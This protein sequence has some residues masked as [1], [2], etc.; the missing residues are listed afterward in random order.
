MVRLATFRGYGCFE[1]ACWLQKLKAPTPY[2]RSVSR[3]IAQ[4][5]CS[6][7]QFS[8][9]FFRMGFNQDWV[10]DSAGLGPAFFVRF[11]SRIL[12]G[13]ERLDWLWAAKILDLRAGD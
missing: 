3:S 12:R 2:A 8:R 9:R 10:T 13:Y 11:G 6:S 4:I 1:A 5:W 7:Q